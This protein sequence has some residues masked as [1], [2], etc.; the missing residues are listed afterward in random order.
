MITAP[1]DGGQFQHPLGDGSRFVRRLDFVQQPTPDGIAQAFLIGAEHIGTDTVAL[2][3]GDNVF[4]GPG[5]GTQLQHH[6]G[7]T[8]GLVFGYRV[9]DPSAYGVATMDAQGRAYLEQ[10][11]LQVVIRPWGTAWL[12]TGTISDLN[13][14]SDFIRALENRQGLKVGA[15]EEVGRR[16]GFLT[17][18]ELRGRAEPLL[19]SG[20]GQYLLGLLED[21]G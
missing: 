14:A 15:P 17:D 12:D 3:L 11:R 7:V 4:Y 18:D 6:T 21:E 9:K 13:D 8:G 5:T 1:Q 16:Q 19:E 2:I 20:C 10:G